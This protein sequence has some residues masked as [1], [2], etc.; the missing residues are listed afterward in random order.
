LRFTVEPRWIPWLLG[1][2]YLLL[3]LHGLG[4]FDVVGDDEAREVAIMQNVLAGHWLWPR[5][6]DTLIPD[7]PILSHWLG[8]LSCAAVGFSETAVRF[9]FV[10]AG[11]L[12]ICWTTWFGM[13]TLGRNGG[14]AAGILL[15][16]FRA[17]FDHVRVAR[18][19]AIMLPLLALA[20]GCAFEAWR[21]GSRRQALAMWVALG[22]ATFAK[23]PVAP[24]LFVAA[25][26]GFLL[27]ER[28]RGVRRLLHPVGIVVCVIL[29]GWWYVAAW[30]GWGD[31]F[32][33]QHVIGRYMRNLAGG[34]VQGQA[35]S[36]KSW[37]HHATFYPLHL[38]A[39]ALPWTPLAAAALW[40]AWRGGS[41]ARPLVRFL[42]CW[43]I[44]P[45]LVFTPAEYKLRYYLL[46]AFPAL[47]LLMGPLAAELV[48]RPLAAPRATRTSL[49]LAAL[50]IV[51][52]GAGAWV[53][54]A[55]PELL[56]RS[57]QATMAAVVAAAPFGSSG[58]A[59]IVGVVLGVA[60]TATALR[61]WGPLVGMTAVL[62]TAW[63]AFGAPAVAEMTTARGSFR[64][65]AETAKRR[66][67]T[68]GSLAF[69]GPE[70]RAIVVYVGHPVASLQRDAGRIT[71]GMGI[72]A[73][74]PA[75]Q[76]LA[77]NGYVGDSLAMAEG[78]VGNLERGTL[79]LAEGRRPTTP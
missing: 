4:A 73:T 54:L 41:F 15:A 49:G 19:D 70:S 78:Q 27:W 7:K 26:G 30:A 10:L 66:F 62:A 24:A 79:V 53:A 61:L 39:I 38:P 63:L 57:D 69:Y 21:D 25:L 31:E 16:T 2:A 3:A 37:L 9:P 42:A 36:P 46:P 8:A 14:I 72:I 43:A 64:A 55:R 40:R 68:P 23:G 71:P 12:T 11:A 48:T 52:V 1:A 33:R 45:V 56:S 75:F 29:G 32:V 35:Y 59:A 20:L 5:F 60:A 58:A 76:V 18:P 28:G 6:N 74:L 13:R 44:A 50:L 67:P 47:A 17:L 34:L 65:F 77:Q 51:V 22:L